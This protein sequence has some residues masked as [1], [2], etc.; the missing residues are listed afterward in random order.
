MDAPVRRLM[1]ALAFGSLLPAGCALFDRDTDRMVQSELRSK[2]PLP[3]P[4]RTP[5]LPQFDTPEVPRGQ[6]PDGPKLPGGPLPPAPVAPGPVAP[7]PVAPS[8]APVTPLPA[9]ADPGRTDSPPPPPSSLPPSPPTTRVK[10]VATIGPEYFVTEEE[11]AMMVRQRARDYIALTGEERLAKERE[12]YRDELKKL[13]ERELIVAEFVGRV[14]KNKPEALAEIWQDAGKIADRQIRE[15]RRMND[16]TTEEKFTQALQAMGLNLK[17]YKRNVERMTMTNMYL[18]E[19]L[20]D[21]GKVISL[22]EIEDYYTRHPEEFRVDDRVVWQHLFVS[23]AGSN[24]PADAKKLADWLLKS[25]QDGGDVS[26]LATEHG[27]GDSALR[28]GEGVGTKRGEIL[29]RELEPT[30]LGLKAGQL[31]AVVQTA[32]GYH[33]VKV[34]ERD[35][36][37]VRPFDAKVQADV[38]NKLTDQLVKQERDKVVGDLW[39]RSAVT[40]IDK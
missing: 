10:L 30:V 13:I 20:K 18:R 4:D 33:V 32:T 23:F 12:V 38:R 21:K 26:K 3:T 7:A 19:L 15:L 1:T 40:V 6:M 25:A 9:D 22:A 5:T 35:V 29:P 34:L 8:P 24:S 16:L 27:H 2:H 36:A 39:R 37:G 17:A 11:V 28:A 31:S 14:R